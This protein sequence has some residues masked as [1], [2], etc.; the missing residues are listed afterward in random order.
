MKKRYTAEVTA[1]LGN[2]EKVTAYQ[3]VE[4]ES[5]EAAAEQINASNPSIVVKKIV[6]RSD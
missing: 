2:G 4:A 1:Q 6:E 5:A 3:P